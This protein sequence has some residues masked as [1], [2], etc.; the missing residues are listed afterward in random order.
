MKKVRFLDNLELKYLLLDRYLCKHF[1]FRVAV[2]R[3]KSLH[4]KVLLFHHCKTM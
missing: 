4:G 1:K 3:N 2:R